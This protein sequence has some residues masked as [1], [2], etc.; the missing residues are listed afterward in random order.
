MESEV[1]NVLDKIKVARHARAR[2]RKVLDRIKMDSAHMAE[3]IVENAEAKVKQLI[4]DSVKRGKE[5]AFKQREVKMSKARSESATLRNKILSEAKLKANAIR[6][7]AVNKALDNIFKTILE[8]FIEWSKTDKL[9]YTQ[10]LRRLIIEGTTVIG[11]DVE[12]LVRKEDLDLDLD[13]ESIS[14]E[15]KEEMGLDIKVVYSKEPL[16]ASGGVVVRNMRGR[17][18]VHNTFEAIIERLRKKLYDR[19]LKMLLGS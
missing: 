15:I 3:V 18:V 4:D 16:N 1:K 11:E 8:D 13:L 2:A 17:V 12:I 19:A 5:D 7:E 14:K 10:L 6:L 9:G